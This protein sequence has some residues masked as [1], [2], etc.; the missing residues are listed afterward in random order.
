MANAC[1]QRLPSYFPHLVLDV[2]IVMPNHIHGILILTH[3]G[4]G[5]AFGTERFTQYENYCPNASPLQPRSTTPGSVGAMI[6]NF[7]SISAQQINRRCQLNTIK[8]W[9][10]NYYEHIVR[11]EESLQRLRQYIQNNPLSWQ[12][13]QLHPDVPSKW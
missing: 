11:N 2:F 4:R 6:Q 12:E 7:K 13:D 9:Q 1:W 8:I 3:P 10:R 5:E